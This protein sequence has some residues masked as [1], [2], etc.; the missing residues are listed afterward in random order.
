MEK[1]LLSMV[2]LA[3]TMLSISACNTAGK[4]PSSSNSSSSSVSTSSSTSS[5]VS[6]SISSNSSSSSSKD[7][8][9]QYSTDLSNPLVTEGENQAPY[10]IYPIPHEIEYKDEN[11][12]LPY[13]LEIVI[14]EN[15]DD[16][17]K[18]HLYD[19]LAKK[20]IAA[21][22]KDIVNNDTKQV[23][24][25]IY[26]SDGVVDKYVEQLVGQQD[27]LF[28]KYDSYYLSINEDKII[29]LGKDSDACF[30]GITTLSTIFNQTYR[31]I[32][33][34][35][36]ED[37]SDS[38]YR[39]FIE[40][41]YGIPWTKDERIELME[42]ASQFKSNIYIYAPKDDSYHS[43]NWRGLYTE[44][45]L[46]DLKEQIA[47]GER[48]KTRFAWSIHPFISDPITR[49]N[50]DEGVNAI[51]TKFEQLY[52]A[53]V[54]QFVVSADDLYVAEGETVDSALHRDLL[55]AIDNWCK[56]KGDCY[57]LIFV[58][59]AYCL[60]SGDHL[61]VN[62][63]TYFQVLC[64]GLN[65][66]IQ[67]MWTGEKICSSVATGKFEEFTQI[68]GRSA[69]MWLN[70]PVT[71]YAESH[72]LMGKGEVLNATIAEGSKPNFAG[73][74]TNPMQ[75]PEQSKLAIFAIADYCWNINAFDMD[76][77]YENSMKF[78]EPTA[79]EEFY[80]LCQHLT[81]ASLYEGEYF[82][83]SEELKPYAQNFEAQYN[84]GN[85]GSIEDMVDLYQEIIDNANNYL[86]T[87]TNIP[88]RDSIKPWI[89]SLKLLAEASILYLKVLDGTGTA[90]E[91][92]QWYDEAELKR[93][94]MKECKTPILN[95]VDYG[96]EYL[97]VDVGTSVLTP[98]LQTLA[99]L[100]QDEAYLS[101]GRY[102]GVTYRGFNGIYEGTADLANDDNP[103]TYVWFND[104][105][106]TNAHIRIDLGEVQEIRDIHILQGNSANRDYMD[107]YVEYSV[108]GR[109]F[110]RIGNLNGLDTTIDLRLNP[111]TA[112]YIRLVNS[113]TSTWVAIKEIDVNTLDNYAGIV[114]FGNIN[115]E[116]SIYGHA[117]ISHMADG[118]DTTFT[119]F[120]IN[121]TE[122]A[123]I[124]LDMLEVKEINTITLHMANE[125]ST[126]DYFHNYSISIS[127]D[128]VN[129]E[130]I[131]EY[132]EV[133]LDLM[134]DQTKQARY[135]KIT[136]LNTDPYGIIVREISA[137]LK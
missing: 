38:M 117:N 41:Y 23:L 105:P 13:N 135:I 69:F 58:P 60:Q 121:K 6:S 102:L 77:S 126:S 100:A 24:V 3:T 82:D 76:K 90:E 10:E 106:A 83:E 124:E 25:G 66:S 55:N 118:D 132:T 74:V 30:Y 29:V 54:R 1:K 92:G 91:M 47:A 89:E 133:E 32:S 88:L 123:Y 2:A 26:N 45:D 79:T 43:S 56:A 64:D 36:V 80:E 114:T 19:A 18:T 137:D 21:T 122:G 46:L 112:R 93:A 113:G 52:D 104:Y 15:I 87:A 59:A 57:D 73:I 71:D 28:E 81:N 20:N 37:Y 12:V 103:D 17:T 111:I 127:T 107:G 63:E 62:L 116:D 33:S 11:F 130:I 125:T 131:G 67:I 68:T 128:G 8:Y 39:G 86:A 22:S 53:G 4:K 97:T 5:K 109:N 95:K 7:E 14:E 120:A 65:E 40:G 16:S 35:E 50:Y 110:T 9:G 115:L 61:G 134:L 94:Q 48:T 42:F 70:W 85:K 44:A 49:S 84:L 31:T 99:N 34:L 78:V 136:A 75:Q 98:L 119:W 72:L 108:D 27:A 129:Y 96:R 101:T 51:I